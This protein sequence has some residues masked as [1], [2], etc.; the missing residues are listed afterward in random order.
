M[1]REWCSSN[2][3][4]RISACV[5]GI[6]LGGFSW[7]LSMRFVWYS[8][9]IYIVHERYAYDGRMDWLIEHHC[10]WPSSLDPKTIV[11]IPNCSNIFYQLYSML[12]LVGNCSI[13]M[14]NTLKQIMGILVTMQQTDQTLEFKNA[15][16]AE[17]LFLNKYPDLKHDFQPIAMGVVQTGNQ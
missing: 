13:E 15:L 10:H 16:T 7:K 14:F 9:L 8:S 5:Y 6:D 11:S 12:F 1:S 2:G 17:Q 4:Q 3:R